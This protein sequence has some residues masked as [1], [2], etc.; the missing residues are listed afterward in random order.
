MNLNFAQEN[1]K[2]ILKFSNIQM[3]KVMLDKCKATNTDSYLTL[4][5]FRT[6]PKAHNFS[7]QSSLGPQA[8]NFEQ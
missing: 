4:L 7:G 6:T 1:F 5:N 8:S 3:I 2:N